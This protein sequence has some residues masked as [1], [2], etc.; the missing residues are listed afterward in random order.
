[1]IDSGSTT[2]LLNPEIATQLRFKIDKNLNPSNISTI[3]GTGSLEYSVQVLCPD[4]TLKGPLRFQLLKWHN[5][6]HGLIGNDILKMFNINIDYR[7][8]TLDTA[9]VKENYPFFGIV[10]A[11]N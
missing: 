11:Q 4:L 9:L 10:Q 1:M 7:K 5:Y 2:S 3:H 8:N 6:F